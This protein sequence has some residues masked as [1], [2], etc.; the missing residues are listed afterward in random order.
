MFTYSI[1]KKTRRRSAHVTYI[2]VILVTFFAVFINTVTGFGFGIISVALFSLI[3]PTYSAVALIS[4]ITV[5]MGFMLTGF[6]INHVQWRL[7]IIPVCLSLTA[8]F[9]CIHFGASLPDKIAKRVLGAFLIILSLYFVFFSG[10]VRIKA[11]PKSGA[12]MGILSGSFTGLFGIGGPPM[13]LYYLVCIDEKTK[14]MATL[15]MHF[16]IVNICMLIIRFFYNQLT[17]ECWELFGVA[18]IPLLAAVYLGTKLFKL[19]NE[20]AL[21]RTIYVFMALCGGYYLISR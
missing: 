7:L 11:T 10:R 5:V 19:L 13:V 8:G 20:K 17:V 6:R 4:I 12:V 21:R 15:Q 18:I 2:F 14:Y 9:F 16:L 3:M 1:D